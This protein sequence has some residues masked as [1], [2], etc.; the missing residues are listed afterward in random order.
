MLVSVP[1][2]SVMATRDKSKEEA[3]R[4]QG[5][6]NPHPGRVKDE[7]FLG[8]RF[9]DP[10]DLVQVRYEMLRRVIAEGRTVTDTVRS[11]GFTRRTWYNACGAFAEHGLA[12]LV[13]ERPGPR[14]RHK[15]TPEIVDYLVR[16]RSRRPGV[17]ATELA[18]LVEERF[19]LSV[20]RRSIERALKAKN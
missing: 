4:S 13:Y 17:G 16:V 6:L 15:L 12:G 8:N 3:L 14:R 9:F 2:R 19:G 20:H 1:G 10:R 18:R 5:N 7:L 11:F